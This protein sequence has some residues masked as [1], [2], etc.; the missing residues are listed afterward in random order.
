MTAA[1]AKG[2]NMGGWDLNLR[3]SAHFERGLFGRDRR[4]HGRP[5]LGAALLLLVLVCI[6]TAS[7]LGQR[8]ARRRREI[9][10]RTSLGATSRRIAS[11][12][13]TEALLLALMGGA[14]GWAASLVLA[15]VALCNAA[16]LWHDP[17]LQPSHRL[18]RSR[19]RGCA[20]DG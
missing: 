18:A 8:A 1:E 3:D 4:T 2:G 10:I 19:I 11:Q 9:A 5:S 7:L 12:L 20:G 6:N 13:F 14:V 16:E 17:G 15:Q